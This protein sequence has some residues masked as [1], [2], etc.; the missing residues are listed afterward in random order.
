MNS[1]KT[2]NPPR[3]FTGQPQL[4]D[5]AESSKERQTGPDTPDADLDVADPHPADEQDPYADRQ[6]DQ[7]ESSDPGGVNPSGAGP[8]QPLP[9]NDHDQIPAEADRETLSPA[10]HAAISESIERQRDA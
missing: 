4:R 9:D 8:A 3:H 10:E 7:P 5:T 2:T 1:Q 6:S